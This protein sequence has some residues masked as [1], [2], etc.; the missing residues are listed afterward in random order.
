MGN[1]DVKKLALSI[2]KDK[3]TLEMFRCLTANSYIRVVKYHNTA[4]ADAG[5]FEREIAAYSR[6][7]SPVNAEDLDRFFETRKWHKDKPGLIPFLYDGLRNQYDVMAPIL[8]KYGFCGWFFVPGFLLDIPA[9]EQYAA[10]VTH[11][12]A[13]V[14]P[15]LYEDGR[16]FFSWQE[17]REL[18]ERN[19]ICCHTGS[20]VAITPEM[21]AA[22]MRREIVEAKRKIEEKTDRPVVA[23]SWKSGEEYGYNVHTHRYLEEAGY[24]YLVSS[25][26]IEKIG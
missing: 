24:R 14:E 17:L 13:D 15:A 18:A 25:L 2:T 12:L 6:W 26:K 11:D 23:F 8:R 5:R 7:F 3:R 9:K 10:S 19:V 1:L 4:P 16:C 21:A 22:E 20:H